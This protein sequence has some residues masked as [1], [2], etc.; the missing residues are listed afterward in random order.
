MMTNSSMTV[1]WIPLPIIAG[2]CSLS[3]IEY[4]ATDLVVELDSFD[5]ERTIKI[6]FSDVF[7]KVLFSLVH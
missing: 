7:N 1:Q 6:T 5:E 3:S 2:E 4:N